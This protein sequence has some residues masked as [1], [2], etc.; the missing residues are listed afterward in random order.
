MS[1]GQLPYSSSRWYRRSRSIESTLRLCRSSAA[2][3]S[4]PSEAGPV[5]AWYYPDI[6][7]LFLGSSVHGIWIRTRRY[8]TARGLR[9]G[10]SG[11]RARRL[12]GQR[13][14]PSIKPDG[15]SWHRRGIWSDVFVETLHGLVR[16]I[17][18]GRSID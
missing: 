5:G 9:V 4:D 18:V 10:D 17:Y 11:T 6:E 2:D 15:L 1:P 16:A 12:Y 8:A 7:V 13:A 3:G 14:S